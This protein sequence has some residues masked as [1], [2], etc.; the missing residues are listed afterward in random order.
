LRKEN[1][2]TVF[3]NKVLRNIFGPK[4]DEVRG[5]WRR[6]HKVE[7]YY[8]CC[9]LNIIREIKSWRMRWPGHVERVEE[10]IDAYRLLVRKPEGK[11]PLGRVNMDGSIILKLILQKWDWE[12]DWIDLV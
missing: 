5:E 7:L 2:L 3:E 10:R 6:T 1:R 9:Q 12:M 11:R 4:R 8:L